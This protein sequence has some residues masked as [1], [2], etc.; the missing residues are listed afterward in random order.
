MYLNEFQR[1]NCVEEM[2][3]INKP[4]AS[5][6]RFE[7]MA[8]GEMTLLTRPIKTETLETFHNIEIKPN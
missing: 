8:P 6:S 1:E 4:T 3:K 7:H 2:A 5:P